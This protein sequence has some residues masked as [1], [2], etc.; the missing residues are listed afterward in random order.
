MESNFKKRLRKKL[1]DLELGLVPSKEKLMWR[2]KETRRMENNINQ[3][4]S[5][6][7]QDIQEHKRKMNAN[8][9]N[10]KFGSRNKQS[11]LK[12]E[13]IGL[14]ANNDLLMNRLDAI[15]KRKPL[16]GEETKEAKA[17]SLMLKNKRKF[18]KN[19]TQFK[20][21][22]IQK[23]NELMLNRLEHVK[24]SMKQVEK[25]QQDF[26]QHERVKGMFSRMLKSR[27]DNKAQPIKKVT[28]PVVTNHEQICS[29]YSAIEEVSSLT[30]KKKGRA[31]IVYHGVTL[32]K[33]SNAKSIQ[34]YSTVVE[35]R[36][37]LRFEILPFTQTRTYHIT[38]SLAEF[39]RSIKA[40]PKREC[41]LQTVIQ[42]FISCHDNEF[43]FN[44]SLESTS[45]KPLNN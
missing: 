33:T 35:L 7:L 41:S 2:K 3:M 40:I 5:P 21:R 8:Q 36:D 14:K 6:I 15:A 34:C 12:L 25:L 32:I 10:H 22:Q 37:Q 17:R 24:G 9:R 4:K 38:I 20:K 28:R 27:C 39:I 18:Q 30:K 42:K 44:S 43:V 23:E 16:H 31:N 45:E 19:V 26:Q 29:T 11:R 1:K 13:L